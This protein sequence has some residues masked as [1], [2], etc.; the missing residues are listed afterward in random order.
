MTYPV[1]MTKFDVCRA[2]V[3]WRYRGVPVRRIAMAFRVPPED[4]ATTLM[5]IADAM[6]ARRDGVRAV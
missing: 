4:L 1:E 2:Y 3:M 6:E 5:G